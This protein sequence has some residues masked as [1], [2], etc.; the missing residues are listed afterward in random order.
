[1]HFQVDFVFLKLQRKTI[2]SNSSEI[3]VPHFDL[4][5]QEIKYS[6]LYGCQMEI[7]VCCLKNEFTA[8][9]V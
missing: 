5:E 4:T 6:S 9:C 1:M 7:Q 8:I 3:C 2:I